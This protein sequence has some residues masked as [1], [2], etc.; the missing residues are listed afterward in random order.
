[1]RAYSAW[2]SAVMASVSAVA[3]PIPSDRV[4]P[5]SVAFSILPVMALI[6]S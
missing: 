2:S 1:M 4:F 5:V 3:I 6:P